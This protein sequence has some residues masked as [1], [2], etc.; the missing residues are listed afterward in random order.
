MERKN[1]P[2]QVKGKKLDILAQKRYGTQEEVVA[3]FNR[4]KERL[5]AIN[6][7]HKITKTSSATFE[8]LNHLDQAV[9]RRPEVGDYV[10]ID[11]PGPGSIVGKGYDWVRVVQITDRASE[12]YA[13]ITLQ[14]SIPPAGQRNR[15][16]VA[17]FFKPT[18]SSTI[19]IEVRELALH[20]NY[21][22]RNEEP[23]T[24]SDLFLENAR[25][26]IIGIGAMFGLSYPQWKKLVDGLLSS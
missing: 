18:S 16:E 23:N 5:F 6:D 11:I 7:W 15:N 24:G 17:H 20:A 21:F 19:E 9:L 25:N 4:A 1:I 12:R 14:P 10:K 8:L 3:A 22:G 13:Q 2:R 26:S